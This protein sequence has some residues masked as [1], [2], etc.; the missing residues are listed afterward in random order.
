MTCLEVVNENE[1]YSKIVH[2]LLATNFFNLTEF[3]LTKTLPS[4]F[5]NY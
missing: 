1:L 5:E 3:K 2:K 4:E